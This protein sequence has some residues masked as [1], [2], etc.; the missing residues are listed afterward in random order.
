MTI[1]LTAD[2]TKRIRIKKNRA[3][4]SCSSGFSAECA[5]SACSD[6]VNTETLTLLTVSPND[7]GND[8]AYIL[9]IASTT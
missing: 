9:T 3:S 7:F 2:V 5:D 8:Y 6:L 1:N 4:S